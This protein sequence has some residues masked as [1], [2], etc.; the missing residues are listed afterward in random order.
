M[1]DKVCL[2]DGLVCST[3]FRETGIN[4]MVLVVGT[5]GSGKTTSYTESRL[6]HTFDTSLIVPLAKGRVKTE[7]ASLFK[8]RGY[9]VIDLDFANPDKSDYGYDPMDYIK[10]NMDEM[11]QAKAILCGASDRSKDAQHSGS[12]DPYWDFSTINVI[13][14]IIGVVRL[15]AMAEGKR[16][17]FYDVIRFADS[18]KAVNSERNDS[19]LKTNVDSVFEKAEELCPGNQACRLWQSL[20]VPPKTGNTIL[21]MVKGAI[22]KTFS[23]NVV[24]V[25]RKENRIDFRALG[26]E[27][28]I[29]FITTSPFDTGMGSLINIMYTDLFRSLFEEAESREENRLEIPVHVICDDFAC[30]GRIA[31]F[32]KYISIFRAAGISA[33]LLLQSESQL[34]AMY[35][36]GSA[37]TIINNCDTYLY[38]GGRDDATCTS[39]SRWIN[40]PVSRVMS[41]PPEYVYVFRRGMKPME[42]KRYQTYED[43]L[44]IE[45][46]SKEVTREEDEDEKNVGC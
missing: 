12:Y 38:M 40:K 32:E 25:L 11:N 31:D 43:A 24:K 16:P 19:S 45:A 13:A 17:S 27:K 42:A 9:K 5:T 18:I 26:R 34:S 14:A 3:D 6:L 46:F 33:S 1:S 10:T 7:Y 28:T 2:A 22:A 37:Q 36:N 4:D 44:Y 8:D 39:V 35:G 15:N 29:V 23:E 30:S 21:G 41:L 20:S